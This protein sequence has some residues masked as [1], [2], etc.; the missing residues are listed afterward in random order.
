MDFGVEDFYAVGALACTIGNTVVKDAPGE[1]KLVIEEIHVLLQCV[2]LFQEEVKNPN[3][4]LV[5][6]GKE[7]ARAVRS[8]LER[9]ETTLKGLEKHAILLEKLGNPTRPKIFKWWD[10]LSNWTSKTADTKEIAVLQ[11]KVGAYRRHSVSN[12]IADSLLIQLVY[13]NAM[14]NQL[15]TLWGK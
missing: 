13:H 8:E 9:V 4:T 14:L 2:D 5:R 12:S 3:S 10:K 1:W 15:L 11:D 7:R 6:S